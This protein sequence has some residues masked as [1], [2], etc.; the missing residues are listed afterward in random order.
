VTEIQRYETHLDY[1]SHDPNGSFVLYTDHIAALEA[2]KAT[3]PLPGD[4]EKALIAVLAAPMPDGCTVRDYLED[5]IPNK[6]SLVELGIN[7]DG[8]GISDIRG[9]IHEDFYRL[10][11]HTILTAASALVP[12]PALE[13]KTE[14]E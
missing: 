1:I 14:G 11:I 13:A 12:S 8:Y 4:Y 6:Q 9:D 2:V 5:A 7:V 3:E 10:L